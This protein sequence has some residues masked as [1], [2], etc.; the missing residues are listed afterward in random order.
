MH[1]H[2]T[3]LIAVAKAAKQLSSS[4]GKRLADLRQLQVRL[5]RTK[6]GM[7]NAKKENRSREHATP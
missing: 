7:S 5:D 6:E 4:S 3:E 1:N 2:I